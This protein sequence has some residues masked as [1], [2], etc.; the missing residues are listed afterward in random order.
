MTPG[1]AIQSHLS[2]ASLLGQTH[3]LGGV[4]QTLP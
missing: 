3:D 1:M 2:L 4:S